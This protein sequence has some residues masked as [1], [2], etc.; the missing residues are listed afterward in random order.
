MLLNEPANFL[1]RTR[2]LRE[3]RRLAVMAVL[4]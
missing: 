1:V 3:E 2:H 4:L